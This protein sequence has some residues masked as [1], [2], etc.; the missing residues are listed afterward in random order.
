MVFPAG[1]L[2]R[3]R[4]VYNLAM[5]IDGKLSRNHHYLM[6]ALEF[7]HVYSL[8]HDDLPAMDDDDL[9][10]GK[11]SLHK[12]ASEGEAILVGDALIN[13]SYEALSQ[14]RH[15][16]AIELISM[17][18]KLMGPLG[19]IEGQYL[20]LYQENKNWDQLIHIHQLKTSYLIEFALLATTKVSQESPK[21]DLSKLAKAIGLSFQLLD[22]KSELKDLSSK[23]EEKKN[24]FLINR[25]EAQKRLDQEMKYI[26]T[27]FK[28]N[29]L[30]R[31]E[32]Q[33]SSWL[34]K[35]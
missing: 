3:P 24:A 23:D 30:P 7:H 13:L 33:I 8:I 27:F 35:D 10:R 11:L 20:D 34:G 12:Y 21:I 17:F 31:L 16:F 26:K 19:L 6:A 4:L 15:P 2:F 18:S 22:D 25:K 28:E 5:D 29:K 32:E 1:K 9:R 14:I